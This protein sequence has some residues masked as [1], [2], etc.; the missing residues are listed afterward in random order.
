MQLAVMGAAERYRELVA[1]LLAEPAGLREPQV[2]RVARLSAA[3]KVGLLS[4]EA[5]VQLVAVPPPLWEGE[6]V[7]IRQ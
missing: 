4:H 3:N 6:G 5:Q 7:G 1:D 2:M